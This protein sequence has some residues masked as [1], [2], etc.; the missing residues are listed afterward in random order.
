M[1][2][3]P[4]N[5]INLHFLEVAVNYLCNFTLFP[6]LM[7]RL[8]HPIA[9]HLFTIVDCCVYSHAARSFTSFKLMQLLYGLSPQVCNVNDV[10]YLYYF[11][12]L[13]QLSRLQFMQVSPQQVLGIAIGNTHFNLFYSLQINVYTLYVSGQSIIFV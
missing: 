10:L 11:F 12:F 9:L 6:G 4:W 2:A 1:Y 5:I 3:L 8:L 13:W 7:Y